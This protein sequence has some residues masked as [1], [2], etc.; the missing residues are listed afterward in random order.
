MTHYVVG[1]FD[2]QHNH[3]DICTSANDC[4]EAQK[5]VR[6]DSPYLNEHPHAI[7]SIFQ[8]D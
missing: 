6:E 1:Y 8:E 5:N 7:D 2:G 4:W 3:Q